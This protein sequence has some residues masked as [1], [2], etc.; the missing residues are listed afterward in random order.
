MKVCSHG[1]KLQSE[2]KLPEKSS[3]LPPSSNFIKKLFIGE[4]KKSLFIWNSKHSII[5]TP[6]DVLKTKHVPDS[7]LS[8]A[9]YKTIDIIKAVI[10]VE[11]A[12]RV[13][14]L[15]YSPQT[16]LYYL[17]VL[18][19]D[20]SQIS[21]LKL[22]HASMPITALSLETQN[23]ILVVYHN[24]IES[25]AFSYGNRFLVPSHDRENTINIPK[26]EKVT[27]M[28]LQ[29]HLSRLFIAFPHSIYV[30]DLEKMNF[31][32][33][34]TEPLHKN[35]ISN[36]VL[37]PASI[38]KKEKTEI[39]TSDIT[40]SMK[41][42][43]IDFTQST[44]T[45][46][47]KGLLIPVDGQNSDQ[48]S[49]FGLQPDSPHLLSLQDGNLSTW[50]ISAQQVVSNSKIG[51][52]L[53]ILDSEFIIEET[54][55][56][57]VLHTEDESRGYFIRFDALIDTSCIIDCRNSKIESVYCESLNLTRSFSSDGKNLYLMASN[58][59]LKE[60]D[61]QGNDLKLHHS[62]LWEVLLV[63]EN[64][65]VRVFDTVNDSRL[66][67]DTY[68]LEKMSAFSLYEHLIDVDYAVEYSKER[69]KKCKLES[70]PRS[71]SVNEL[72]AYVGFKTGFIYAIDPISGFEKSRI[73]IG[74]EPIDS[75]KISNKIQKDYG[76]IPFMITSSNSSNIISIFKLYPS[77]KE[78][79]I[80]LSNV[81]LL[82]PAKEI[83][84]QNSTTALIIQR[85]QET[86]T[87]AVTFFNVDT[88]TWIEH[89][90][91][92]DHNDDI[93]SVFAMPTLQIV[94]TA[95][96]DGVIGIWDVTNDG[97]FLTRINTGY[98]IE[99]VFINGSTG[100]LFFT[101]STQSKTV[102][103]RIDF[104][105]YIPTS[106]SLILNKSSTEMD[107]HS[108]KNFSW[109]SSAE[110]K[111]IEENLLTKSNLMSNKS[112]GDHAKLS[113]LQ[114]RNDE[115]AQLKLKGV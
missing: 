97:K 14:A 109:K 59:N 72:I 53:K 33:K 115:L 40:G 110:L 31:L 5:K 45:I 15:E 105:S 75:I 89:D 82:K 35:P 101:S 86:F 69:R 57:L 50:D 58:G 24:L 9:V 66:C 46:S 22:N 93:C 74:S 39:I 96:V 44:P 111:S 108:H 65:T 55:V 78:C 83:S 77:I 76:S 98:T 6:I 63:A 3:P 47:Q 56:F 79:L 28:K 37:F 16:Y 87:N 18:E 106:H 29:T 21:S 34:F 17:K 71:D 26:N 99:S 114:K 102:L 81:E 13:I 67:T 90:P 104:R 100:D 43:E 103:H 84:F 8:T 12:D 54:G 49:I 10:M 92:F 36:I 30:V 62:I 112:A 48:L 61:C 107:I 32:A 20:L 4:S 19:S 2:F 113:A 91:A 42:W 27:D 52:N 73:K 70:K 25:F 68:E 7:P 23:T 41:H 38:S 94:A 88:H 1:L 51:T 60:F 95:S 85:N 80:P 64:E 11:F